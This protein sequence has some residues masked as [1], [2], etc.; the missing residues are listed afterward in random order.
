M[1]INCDVKISGLVVFCGYFFVV[2][3]VRLGK[4]CVT[5]SCAQQAAFWV[6]MMTCVFGSP[7]LSL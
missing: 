7:A 5:Y 4:L 6:M 3:F 1:L 2:V